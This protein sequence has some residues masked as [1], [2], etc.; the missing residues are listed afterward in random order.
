MGD[1][2]AAGRSSVSNNNNAAGLKATPQAVS[3]AGYSQHTENMSKRERIHADCE[4]FLMRRPG[5]GKFGE[6]TTVFANHFRVRFRAHTIFHYDVAIEPEP[7]KGLHRA[8]LNQGVQEK[9]P[10]ARVA[11]DG[12]RSLY[13]AKE[14]PLQL[15]IDIE[16]AQDNPE[17]PKRDGKPTVGLVIFKRKEDC[18]HKVVSWTSSRSVCVKKEAS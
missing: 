11:Y 9:L 4:A 10:R 14:L 3:K 12:Q 7:P 6:A 2:R 16:L 13:T 1:S 8:V 18:K 15:E 5:Y 17:G